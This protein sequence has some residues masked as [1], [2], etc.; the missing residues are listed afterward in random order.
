MLDRRPF[1]AVFALC[2]S[3]TCWTTPL[4]AETAGT[5]DP[6]SL[7]GLHDIVMPAPIAPWWPLAPGWYLLAGLLVV[8]VAWVLWRMRKRRLVTRYRVE[9]VAQLRALRRERADPDKQAAQI[10]ALL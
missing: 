10:L 1:F 5:V 2:L 8:L 6:A 3:S 4:R 7:S 9:A